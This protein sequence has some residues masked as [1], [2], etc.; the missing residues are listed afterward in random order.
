MNDFVFYLDAENNSGYISYQTERFRLDC[1]DK[2]KMR[3]HALSFFAKELPRY[4]EGERLDFIK[5]FEDFYEANKA[6]IKKIAKEN[7]TRRKTE[8]SEEEKD[9]AIL[10]MVAGLESDYKF[11][12]LKKTEEILCYD[13]N[14]TTGVWERDAEPFILGEIERRTNRQANKA[15]KG[16]VLPHIK[17][18]SFVEPSDFNIGSDAHDGLICLKQGVLDIETCKLYPFNPD[19]KFLNRYDFEYPA[20]GRI[21]HKPLFIES[22]ETTI[23]D[24]SKRQVLIDYIATGLWS[25]T[26]IQRMLWLVGDGENGKDWICDVVS[27]LYGEKNITTATPHELNSDRFAPAR[28]Y[29]MSACISADIGDE[30]LSKSATLK[31]AT[32]GSWLSCQRKGFDGFPFKYGGIFLFGCNHLP[33]VEDKTRGFMRRPIIVECNETFFDNRNEYNEHKEDLHA[34]LKDKTLGERCTTPEE[35]ACLFV[36]LVRRLRK[37]M[38]IGYIPDAPT[39]EENLQ[40]WEGLVSYAPEWLESEGVFDNSYVVP[41]R[42]LFNEYLTFCESRGKKPVSERHFP[43]ALENC[44]RTKIARTTTKSTNGR[45]VRAFRGITTKNLIAKANEKEGQT[46]LVVTHVTAKTDILREQFKNENNSIENS[47]EGISKTS[48]TCVTDSLAGVENPE[49]SCVTVFSRLGWAEPK[50][51]FDNLLRD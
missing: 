32:G 13:K 48:V 16:E 9:N 30:D 5:A 37:L 4:S 12:T 45:R 21:N 38:R 19:F 23:P 36:Y 6:D 31:D 17:H 51:F 46:D 44:N 10:R 26:K 8:E 40:A 34:H 3:T 50:P 47:T 33:R 41:S 7:D 25:N 15:F 11:A 42:G 22:L 1:D 18:N 20:K 35:L 27:K 14:N 28:L 2:L 24:D 43:A 49:F 29:G 39:P